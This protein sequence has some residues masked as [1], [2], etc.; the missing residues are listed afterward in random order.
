MTSSGSGPAPLHARRLSPAGQ[1][2][3]GGP[4][5]AAYVQA[6]R[7]G[8]LLASIAPVV[9]G[10]AWGAA[11][12]GAFDPLSALLFLVGMVLGHSAGNVLND[13]CDDA[14]GNDP[15]NDGRITPFTGG[16][17]V[18]QDALLTRR[19]MTWFVVALLAG[20]ALTGV[21]L[22]A[23]H[24]GPILA[25]GLAM[26]TLVLLYHMP[27]LRLNHRGLGEA[28]VGLMFGV[29]PVTAAAWLQGGPVDGPT[30]L[31]SVPV[32]AWVVNILI[33]NEIPDRVADRAV[34]KLTLIGVLGVRG[35]LVLQVGLDILALVALAVLVAMGALAAWAMV[36]PVLLTAGMT[37]LRLRTDPDSRAAMLRTIHGTLALH[38]VGALSM[39][40]GLLF[41]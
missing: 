31:V 20:C 16:S 10:T 28:L 11:Q 18:I 19:Q 37:P 5:A 36:V 7:P 14:S 26:G 35:A 4:R 6:L 34:G 2:P 8:F 41:A 33:V 24:G 17:R 12:T 29:A 27:P 23:L 3:R 30:L 13:V 9:V 40:A 15:V 38:G 1:A 22:V 25:F 21:G 32:T 39:T